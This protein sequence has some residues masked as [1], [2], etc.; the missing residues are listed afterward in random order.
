VDFAVYPPISKKHLAEP[1]PYFWAEVKKGASDIYKSITQLIL[2]IGKERLFDKYLPP[3][4]LGAFDAETI[5][6]VPYNEIQ[7]L[8]YLNDFNWKITPSNHHTKEF[9]L[10]H[11]K[12]KQLIGEKALAFSLEKDEKQ[13]RAFIREAFQHGREPG[14]KIKIDRNNFIVIYNRWLEEVKPTITIDWEKAKQR[15]I[16]DGDFY[17]ADLLSRDDESAN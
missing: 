2:T 13:L 10:V 14:A 7:A 4:Y 9:A 11:E 17:L 6:F 1:V 8:F 16:I 15:G 3:I 5:A 12:V